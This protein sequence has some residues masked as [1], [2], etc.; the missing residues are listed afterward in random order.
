MIQ[1]NK[2]TKCICEF[3]KEEFTPRAQVKNPRACNKQ[4]CQRKR[5]KINEKEW[6]ERNRELYD[7]KYHNI[8]KQKRME[9]LLKYSK[10]LLNLIEIGRTFLG[11]ALE[12]EI[13]KDYIFKFFIQL[14]IK[15]VKKF[16]IQDKQPLTGFMS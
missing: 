8:M 2:R 14:G 7:K 15:N 10:K 1:C 5:Q 3:C 11:E 4:S 16:W 13:F 6:R 9:L 12:I